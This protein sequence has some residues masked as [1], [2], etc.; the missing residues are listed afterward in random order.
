L[1]SISAILKI[2]FSV[3]STRVCNQVCTRLGAKIATGRAP[4][5]RCQHWHYFT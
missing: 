4:V 1:C 5:V 2:V 3:G